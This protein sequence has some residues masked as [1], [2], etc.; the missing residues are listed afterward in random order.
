[1][2]KDAYSRLGMEEM[3]LEPEL[4]DE[5]E[6]DVNLVATLLSLK[7]II[8]DKTKDTARKVVSGVVQSLL[9]KL[10]L[11]MEQ[12]VRGSLNKASRNRRPKLNEIAWG[13]TVLANLKHYQ[14]KYKTVIPEKLIGYGRK[15]GSLKDV[16]LCIDQSGSMGQSVVYSSIFG[17][18]MASI[19]ALQTRMV[20]FDTEV[21]D[22][23]ENLQDPVDLLFGTQL[24]GG[25]DINRAVRYCQ[26]F[27]R[28][29]AETVF[30][31]VTDLYEGGNEKALLRQIAT[32]K[33]SGVTIVT[34]L[35]L[36]DAGKPSYDQSMADRF[37]QLGVPA[38]ACTPNLFPDLMA[39][40]L[41]KGDIQQWAARNQ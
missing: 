19:A 12:A 4:L 24:G 1:M 17:A 14:P 8:P 34:L 23:T 7:N 10:S 31:L 41:N 6:P 39:T 21:A 11:P 28:R 18:V 22:L 27:I 37:A 25:T 9:R 36:S 40:A 38:F 33:E 15:S 30:V 29:P 13:P 3:L 35:A 32:M 2:Q 5:I 26:E 20:V 16:I